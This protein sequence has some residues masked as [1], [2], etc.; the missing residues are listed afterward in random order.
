MSNDELLLSEEDISNCT[1][2]VADPRLIRHAINQAKNG[3]ED[4]TM[5]TVDP[6]VFI[7]TLAYSYYMVDYDAKQ[8]FVYL[9]TNTGADEYDIIRFLETSAKVIVLPSHFSILLLGVILH[10]ASLGKENPRLDVW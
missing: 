4:I 6:D 10:L 1:S 7:V 5:R 3:F 9:A 2:E 8:V